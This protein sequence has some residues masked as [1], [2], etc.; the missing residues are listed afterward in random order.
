MSWK[1][2]CTHVASGILLGLASGAAFA[3]PPS[4][5]PADYQKIIDASKTESGLLVYSNISLAAWAPIIKAFNAEYPWIKVEPTDLRANEVFER[6]YADQGTGSQS[7]D[8]LLA[9]AP[10]NWMEFIPKGQIEPYDSPEKSHVPTW[11]NPSP[12]VYT[13]SAD[14]FVI[15]YNKALVPEAERPKSIED[16]VSLVQK[17]P[18][19]WR[20][21]LGSYAPNVSTYTQGLFWAFTKHNGEKA[22]D[23]LKVL[24]PATNPY[25]ST[26]PV[27][28]KITTGEYLI[29]YFIVG[30]NIIPYISD[31]ARAQLM[32]WVLPKDA[33][34]FYMR[35]FAITK[36]AKSPNSAK[37][38]LDFIL[39]KEGQTQVGIGGL[40]PYRSDVTDPAAF[41]LGGLS[42]D[43]MIKQVGE[44]NLSLIDFDPA[45]VKGI[46]PMEKRLEAFYKEPN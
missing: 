40:V 33:A 13:I 10:L 29:G 27:L 35:N 5:Y 28:E 15:A 38:L 11:S 18:G 14:P 26:G 6:Y 34:I 7:A 25:R 23:W 41:R 2:A 36:T 43:A 31:P 4:Y 12:G 3:A 21:K 45:M 42:F 44:D 24:G 17:D 30:L 16:I 8:M 32:G 19:K 37:L 22:Y 20:G 1:S 39:S 9:A 46:D